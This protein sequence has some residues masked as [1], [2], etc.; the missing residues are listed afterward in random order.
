M[1][2]KL[3]EKRGGDERKDEEQSMFRVEEGGGGRR[4]KRCYVGCYALSGA[5]LHWSQHSWSRDEQEEEMTPS[6]MP[7][8]GLDTGVS[9]QHG[10]IGCQFVTGVV[11]QVGF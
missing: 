3:A 2:P 9:T 10:E 6:P 8:Q 5:F 7:L 4:R 1:S 11:L